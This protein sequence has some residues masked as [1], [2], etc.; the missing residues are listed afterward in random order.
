M[1]DCHWNWSP[2]DCSC[3]KFKMVLLANL[4]IKSCASRDISSGTNGQGI[5]L[6]RILSKIT[7]QA[8]NSNVLR[9]W[10]PIL[11]ATIKSSGAIYFP[12]SFLKDKGNKQIRQNLSTII[13]KFLLLKMHCS[14]YELKVQLS[15]CQL[16]SKSV[17][18]E[19]HA[20]ITIVLN[21]M[22]DFSERPIL[23]S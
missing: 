7:C 6:L 10:S 21:W 16:E 19:S 3:I 23:Y 13:K 17:L 2:E 14:L 12:G 4:S 9:R 15:I 22:E 1:L 20:H 18:K 8:R 5:C 11:T